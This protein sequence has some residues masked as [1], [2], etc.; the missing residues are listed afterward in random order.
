MKKLFTLCNYLTGTYRRIR[1]LLFSLSVFVTMS[2]RAQTFVHP[3]VAF[4]RADLDQLK[5]N[6]S[7]EPWLSGYNAF[8]NDSHSQLG[9]GQ[10]RALCNGYK[11]TQPKQQRLD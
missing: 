1:L 11:S 3:G 10:K 2:V 4:N 8:K 6:I 5:A 7:R 9:Y